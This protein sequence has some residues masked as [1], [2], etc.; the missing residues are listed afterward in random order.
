MPVTGTQTAAPGPPVEM[1]QGPGETG[2]APAAL[3]RRSLQTQHGA[4][5]HVVLILLLLGWAAPVAA[6]HKG[7]MFGGAPVAFDG[8]TLLVTPE[9]APSVRLRLWGIDT[10]EMKDA[11][12]AR[13]ARDALGNFL[14]WSRRVQCRVVDRDV[15]VHTSITTLLVGREVRKPRG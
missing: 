5:W 9:G 13:Q 7:Q 4:M 10:S 14:D 1:R 6:Q 12:W 11:P 2:V 8:D 3:P 15:H